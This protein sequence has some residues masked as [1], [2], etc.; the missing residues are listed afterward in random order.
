[1]VAE[2]TDTTIAA[3]ANRRAAEVYG[4][5]VLQA[6]I[7]DHPENATRFLLVSQQ[8]I[9]APTGNDKTTIVVFQRADAPGSLLAILQE[10]AARRINLSSLVSRPT[11]TSLGDYCF[12]LDLNGHLSDEL[13]ADALRALQRKHQVKFLGSYPSGESGDSG[14]ADAQSEEDAAAEKWVQFLRSQIRSPHEPDSMSA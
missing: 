13:V 7:E 11:K 12:M 1:M 8:G 5:E 14:E 9:P 4:L 10:F 3:I 2:G 6:D